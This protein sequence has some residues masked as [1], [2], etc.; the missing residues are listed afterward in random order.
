MF[1][2]PADEVLS[3]DLPDGAHLVDGADCRLP[4]LTGF[5][6]MADSRFEEVPQVGNVSLGLALTG[7]DAGQAFSGSVVQARSRLGRGGGHRSRPYASPAVSEWVRGVM[8]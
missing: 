1:I 6:E 3:T 4:L 5:F 2:D 7:F 8:R